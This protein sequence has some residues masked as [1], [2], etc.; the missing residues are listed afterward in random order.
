MAIVRNFVQEE[1]GRV[2]SHTEVEAKLRLVQC[3]DERFLQ[4]DTYGSK[5]REIPGK[6]S[7]SL[8]LT[9]AAFDQLVQ[10]GAKHFDA[11]TN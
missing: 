6:I 10:A 2:A 4:I 8:R 5:N 11:P 7:Q 1:P 3:G 9:K